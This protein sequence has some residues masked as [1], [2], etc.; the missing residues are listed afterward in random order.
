ML[1][2]DT[3]RTCFSHLLHHL[4][5][6]WSRSILTTTEL[7]VLLMDNCV[8]SA[9]GSHTTKP[10]FCSPCQMRHFLF[11]IPRRIGGWVGLSHSSCFPQNETPECTRH[12]SASAITTATLGLCLTAAFF[13]TYSMLARVPWRLSL[14]LSLSPF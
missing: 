7:P 8:R 2:D 3:D 6:K 9:A 13:C 11:P 12:P 4:A 5:R 14:S 10:L 1:R